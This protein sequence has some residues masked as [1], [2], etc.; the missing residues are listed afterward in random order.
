MHNSTCLHD[1]PTAT[2][3]RSPFLVVVLAFA[4]PD[5]GS[6]RKLWFRR[7]EARKDAVE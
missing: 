3:H 4:V 1:M 2:N 6:S 5:P 7:H